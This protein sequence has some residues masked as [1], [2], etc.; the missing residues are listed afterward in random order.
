MKILIYRFF[1][2]SLVLLVNFS[3][4][5]QISVKE[6]MK[7]VQRE[8]FN[9]KK[10][11]VKTD[12]TKVSPVKIEIEKQ[13]KSFECIL[14]VEPVATFEGG[15]NNFYTVI[16][17]N[18]RFPEGRK[19]GRV[20]LHFVVDTTG[21]MTDFEI[22][23]SVSEENSKEVLRIM[24]VINEKYNWTSAQ[25][26][27]KKVKVRMNIPI[28]FKEESS[29]RYNPTTQIKSEENTT[30]VYTIT[31]KPPVFEGGIDNFYQIVQKNLKITKKDVGTR[32]FIK[33][34]I[35]TTG[36][37]INIKILESNF[38]KENNLEFLK[39]LDWINSTYSWQPA[40]HKGKKVSVVMKLP[41]FLRLE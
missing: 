10:G 8:F 21:K 14:I 41:I 28:V 17:E 38:S 33:Y 31:E 22:M 12:S 40:M 36:K 2:F 29:V 5:G 26:R 24:N 23:K 9:T 27:G 15:M 18:S 4:F 19:E 20:F 13:E 16:R 37:M 1:T 3:V 11:R 7:I 6:E 30:I 34:I 39:T 25:Q 35:D 32:V